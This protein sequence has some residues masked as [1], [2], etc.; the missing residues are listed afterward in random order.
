MQSFMFNWPP[1]FHYA[2]GI[3]DSIGEIVGGEYSSALLVCAKGP[4]RENGLFDR[5]KSSLNRAGVKVCEMEDIDSNPRIASARQGAKICRIEKVDLVVGLGGGSAM[6][7]AKVIAAAAA[8]DCDPFQFLWG[9][10]IQVTDSLDT[11][12]IPT[13]AATGTESNDFAVMVDGEKRE[14]RACKVLHARYVLL[15]P[16]VVASVPI[17]L[18]LWGAMDILS[19][20]FEFYFNGY[21]ESS[22]PQRLAESI[23]IS[24]MEN[25]EAMVADPADPI[26]RGELLW[27][28]TMAWGGLTK[29]GRGPG[30]MACHNFD[31]GLSGYLDTHHGASLGVLTPR[32]MDVVAPLRPE[33]FAEFGRRVMQVRESDDLA[34]AKAGVE[35][36][37]AWLKR[38]GAPNTL[39]D[40]IP[41]DLT[42]DTDLLDK[43]ADEAWRVNGGSI[44]QIKK[45]SREELRKIYD[46]S[47][48]K[49]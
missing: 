32:W 7:C 49:Y 15:D 45:W 3:V 11:V 33:L 44:G 5:I 30:D 47:L 23:L 18:A 35:A 41:A 13:I 1:S 21:N 24:V 42:L 9:E 40:I 46:A 6:D 38:V 22:W 8:M 19:H 16:Q 28:A 36:Y 26:P 27:L 25:V 17:K 43:A 31:S 14:K 2:E 12:M 4:F 39:H 34:A 37:K 48:E 10:R 20:T 29:L